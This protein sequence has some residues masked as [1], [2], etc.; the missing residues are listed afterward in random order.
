MFFRTKIGEDLTIAFGDHGNLYLDH[1]RGDV[2]H[3]HVESRRYKE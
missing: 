3:K 2:T 1:V